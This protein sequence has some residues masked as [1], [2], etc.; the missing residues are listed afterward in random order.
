MALED[1]MQDS[2]A[3]LPS[4]ESCFDA[5]LA[6]PLRV[7]FVAA[8]LRCGGIERALVTIAG[9]LADRG[10]RVT[11]ITYAPASTDFFTLPRNV[12]RVSLDIRAGAPTPVLRLLST[13]RARLRSL[14]AAIDSSEP[15][16]V[17]SHAPQINVPTL[18]AMRGSPVPVVVTEHGDVPVRLEVARPWLWKKWVWYRLRRQHYRRAFKV[19]SVSRA[20]DRNFGWL[21][22]ERR[23]VIHNPFPSIT[24]LTS[25]QELPPG[26]DPGRPWMVSMGRLSHA[27]GHDVLLAA[28][29]CVAARFPQLQLV[30]IGDGELRARLHQLAGELI[31]TQ[32]VIFTGALASPFPLL[33]HAQFF[34]LASR[35]EGFPMAIGEALACGLPVIATD[36]PSRPRKFGER[37]VVGGCGIRELV[38]DGIDGLLVPPEDPVALANA[39]MRWMEDPQERGRLAQ[40]AASGMVRFSREKIVGA[41]ERVLEEATA[42]RHRRFS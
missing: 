40:H 37:G 22:E 32:Q 29:A 6:R 11:V 28:F 21:G 4:G 36:C 27:K 24:P 9:D 1:Q 33:C 30:I 42:T 41:W 7:T 23:E 15:D 25:L 10:H 3:S 17:I 35:Y 26:L 31:E 18:L 14:R 2:C 16:V 19:V 12:A 8:G 5:T 38:R 34:V 20:I 39:I 13:T